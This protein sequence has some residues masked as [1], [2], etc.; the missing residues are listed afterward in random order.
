MGRPSFTPEVRALRRQE[1]LSCVAELL[2]SRRYHEISVQDIAD[3]VGIAKGTFYFYF[4]TKEEVFWELLTRNLDTLTM[5]TIM[6]IRHLAGNV[7]H[8]LILEVLI[9]LTRNHW[10]TIRHLPLLHTVL[11]AMVDA[12]T[13]LTFHH[14]LK[15][16]RDQTAIELYKGT[17]LFDTERQA[18]L[19]V[20]SLYAELVGIITV[21]EAFLLGDPTPDHDPIFQQVTQLI[22]AKLLIYNGKS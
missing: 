20:N 5:E 2:C 17:P 13:V 4:E 8:A 3:H 18:H 6:S 12:N 1:I 16:K 10:Q 19:F 21:H 15:V 11:S 7:D 9:S 14:Q 22:E